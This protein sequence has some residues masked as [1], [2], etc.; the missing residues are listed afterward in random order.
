MA[1]P[2][3]FHNAISYLYTSYF[4]FGCLLA[5]LLESTLDSLQPSSEALSTLNFRKDS[6]PLCLQQH[7]LIDSLNIKDAARSSLY[8]VYM[9]TPLSV[10]IYKITDLAKLKYI[11]YI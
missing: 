7:S 4:A 1:A 8:I 9:F 3:V 2:F 10:L 11:Q 5:V 6:C